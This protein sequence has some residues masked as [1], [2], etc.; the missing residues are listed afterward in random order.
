MAPVL[1]ED[2]ADVGVEDGAEAEAEAEVG[3]EPEVD[4]AEVGRE[5]ADAEAGF[6]ATIFPFSMNLPAFFLQQSKPCSPDGRPQQREPSAQV[7]KGIQRC[8]FCCRIH[9]GS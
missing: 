3:V 9:L 6:V 4:A 2:E 8:R 7:V 1:F 5:V